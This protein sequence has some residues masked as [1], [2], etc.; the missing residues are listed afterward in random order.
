MRC[1]LPDSSSC[2]SYSS[3]KWSSSCFGGRSGGVSGKP[4]GDKKGSSSSRLC[5]PRGASSNAA[6]LLLVRRTLLVAMTP[7]TAC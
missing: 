1:L 7:L 2:T 3:S 5:W 4:S 6:L